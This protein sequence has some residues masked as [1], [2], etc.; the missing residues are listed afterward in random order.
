MHPIALNLLEVIR[1][2]MPQGEWRA[3]T[4][5]IYTDAECHAS[6]EDG[7]EHCD[8]YQTMKNLT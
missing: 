5:N 1:A 7:C 6:P 2:N 3:M 8:L 4:E